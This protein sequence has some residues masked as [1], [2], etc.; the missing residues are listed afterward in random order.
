MKKAGFLR[1]LFYGSPVLAYAG[2]IFFL[3]SV[4]RFPDMVPSFF[5]FD[6]LSHFIEY[7]FFGYLIC[8]WLLSQINPVVRDH[9]FFMTS[10]I[11]ICYGISDEWH[12]SF[13]PGRDATLW[14]ALFDAL[15]VVT[16]AATYQKVI[17]EIPLLKKIDEVFE[18]S[19][20]REEKTG[21]HH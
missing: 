10:M 12:Q 3:S 4:S 1:G 6:K 16:A 17:K 18:R 19:F 20:I 13:V 14:D 9:A 11:G 5:G 7:Y 15:G 21:H 2:L 8:R